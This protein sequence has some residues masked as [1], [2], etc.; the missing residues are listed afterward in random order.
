VED[1]RA[2]A[3]HEDTRIVIVVVRIPSNV[4]PL[5]DHQHALSAA[6]R[7]PLRQHA[8]REPAPTMQ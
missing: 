8:S 6:A 7:Q 5:L 1:V 4:W 2:I 3:M